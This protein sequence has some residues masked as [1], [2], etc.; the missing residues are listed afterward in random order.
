MPQLVDQC[1]SRE[2]GWC[3]ATQLTLDTMAKVSLFKNNLLEYFDQN[4]EHEHFEHHVHHDHHDY[5]EHHEH[6]AC[7]PESPILTTTT[8]FLRLGER[9]E[10]RQVTRTVCTQGQGWHQRNKEK[11]A[12]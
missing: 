10:C 7:L 3:L 11:K 12:S 6:H 2:P 1:L 4:D 5:H 9:E 8:T